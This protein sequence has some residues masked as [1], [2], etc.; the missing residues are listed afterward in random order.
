MNTFSKFAFYALFLGSV[1]AS[2]KDDESPK[3]EGKNPDTAAIM[4]VDRFSAD[5][6]TLMVRDA[7]NGLPAADAP[8]NF[9]QAPFITTGYG[10]N[11]QSVDYYNFDVMP[12]T[13]IPIFVPM[14]DGQPVDGQL[15]IIDKVPG[16]AGYND[17]WQVNEVTV[18]KDYVVNSLASYDDIVAAGY[19]IK[20]T[21]NI[22]NCPVVPKGSTASK[23]FNNADNSLHRGWYKGKLVHYF[24]FEEKALS[25]NSVPISPI[26]VTFNVNPDQP[27][28][29]PASGFVT[30]SGSSQTH[31]VLA[32]LPA[33]AGY[34]PLWS[35]NVF[36]NADFNEVSNLTT[37]QAAN[38]LGSGVALVNCP[39]VK[40]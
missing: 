40:Q 16:E 34:S 22:V 38:I 3:P 12:T 18:P 39:V 5:A 21:T 29:G 8:I 37:A 27:N 11:G 36:D 7:S 10:P 15:F 14:H 26:Y 1:F 32:T 28:G 13:A 17:F 4:P 23:R 2:C 25:G 35:V 31:N 24:T 6:G 9:D 30:E 33:D 19:A 20:P